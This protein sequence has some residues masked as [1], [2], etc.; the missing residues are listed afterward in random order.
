MLSLRSFGLFKCSSPALRRSARSGRRAFFKTLDSETPRRLLY[1]L[2]RLRPSYSLLG[3]GP[4]F[5]SPINM[6]FDRL[7]YTSPPLFLPLHLPGLSRSFRP[8]R[9]LA[10]LLV[11]SLGVLLTASTQ[12]VILAHSVVGCFPLPH[13]H[14]FTCF[15]HPHHFHT[16]P[17]P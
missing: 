4:S 13:F 16:H 11:L 6:P 12:S 14:F 10:P 3:L 1:L 2:L 5:Y 9:S 7:T 15:F 17:Q 8:T